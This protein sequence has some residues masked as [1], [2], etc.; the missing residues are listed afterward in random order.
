MKLVYMYN[1]YSLYLEQSQERRYKEQ[2]SLERQNKKERRK[3]RE[4]EKER[5][6]DLRPVL[7]W[8]VGILLLRRG[9]GWC[10]IRRIPRH[11]WIEIDQIPNLSPLFSCFFFFFFFCFSFFFF[12]FLFYLATFRVR[13]ARN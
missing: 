10:A 11:D 4:R 8:S 2:S 1:I 3:E 12:S 7:W 13:H 9:I 5:E 6:R